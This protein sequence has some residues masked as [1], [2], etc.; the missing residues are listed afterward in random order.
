MHRLKDESV[1]NILRWLTADQKQQIYEDEK[2]RVDQSA[3]RFSDKIKVLIFSYISWFGILYFGIPWFMGPEKVLF[4]SLCLA[5]M[6]LVRPLIA[7]YI[8]IMPFWVLLGFLAMTYS[9]YFTFA[10]NKCP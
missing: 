9:N 1:E 5:G 2:R 4:E 6:T 10:S 3:P 8:C 7:G